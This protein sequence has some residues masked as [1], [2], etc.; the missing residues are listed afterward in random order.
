MGGRLND[1]AF[2]VGNWPLNSHAQDVS[3]NGNDGTWINEAYTTDFRGRSAGSFNGTGKW[4]TIGDISDYD[5]ATSDFSWAFWF[6]MDPSIAQYDTLIEKRDGSNAGY[7]IYC[8]STYKLSLVLEDTGADTDT[9]TGDD[10]LNDGRWH[11]GVATVEAGVE[12]L[13]YIDGVLQVDSASLGSI[14]DISNSNNL[15]FGATSS[16]ASPFYGGLG[17]IR[18]YNVV[19]TADEVLELYRMGVPKQTAVQQ[20]ISQ[21]PDVADSSLV[22]S[23]LNKRTDGAEDL[24][25]NNN[26][27]TATD[28]V[29]GS[30]GAV[31]NG[32]TSKIDFGDVGNLQ[33]IS[34][35]IKPNTTSESILQVDGA[36]DDIIVSS[37][38]VTY[39]AGLTATATY[40]N[41]AASTTLVA[42]KWQYL[43]CQISTKDGNN[44]ELGWDGSSYGDME[45][46]DL[47]VFTTT[48]TPS[49]I[50]TEYARGVPDEMVLHSLV[51]DAKDLSVNGND[52]TPSGGVV[53]GRGGVFDGAD[54]KIDYGDI[55]NIQEIEFWV[56]P[57]AVLIKELAQIDTGP[58]MIYVNTGLISY[59]G[60]TS[61]ATY[62]NGV[63]T[64]TLAAGFWQ[65]V[66]CQMTQV[67]ANNF[68]VGHGDPGYGAFSMQDLI[69]RDPLSSAGDI[70]RRYEQTR[71]YY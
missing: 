24:S 36:T 3:G 43:V 70:A 31:F 7:R 28:V 58:K 33:G 6:K 35:W 20:P 42:D 37:G 27:G 69:V 34:M 22:L 57:T 4:I 41:G 40:V 53:L 49:A 46:R 59:V 26:D 18:A 60:L 10:D 62:V 21:I 29:F 16:L 65:H 17:N 11:Y 71:K 61:S 25:S 52:G 1:P 5:F 12:A 23:S 19:L 32:T 51:T 48:R 13:M 15:V 67:D 55:G 54:V 39:G 56:K 66:V 68:E 2:L 30:T 50:S 9:V 38:T 14:G 47:R 45:V 64:T 44:F 63:A 8:R